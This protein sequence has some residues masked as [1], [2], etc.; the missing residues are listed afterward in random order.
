MLTLIGSIS[1]PDRKMV[2]HKNSK[3]TDVHFSSL[4]LYGYSPIRAMGMGLTCGH[5][6]PRISATYDVF[7]ASQVCQEIH[8]DAAVIIFIVSGGQKTWYRNGSLLGWCS[9]WALPSFTIPTHPPRT[10]PAHP[11][12]Q[13]FPQLCSSSYITCYFLVLTLKCLLSWI[14]PFF[15]PNH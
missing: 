12:Q 8:K 4:K 7:R 10:T 15:S 14:F 13:F 2:S 9:L 11:Q 5:L 3:A 1:M 6:I